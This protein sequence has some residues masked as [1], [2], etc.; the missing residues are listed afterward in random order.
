MLDYKEEGYCQKTKLSTYNMK[1]NRISSLD[2][3]PT[4]KNQKLLCLNEGVEQTKVLSAQ[5]IQI[6]SNLINAVLI[7]HC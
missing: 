6:H 7:Q 5:L 3:L 4:E 2:S 1:W